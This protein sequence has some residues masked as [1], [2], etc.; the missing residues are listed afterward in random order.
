M[1]A[2]NEVIV[3]LGAIVLLAAA[4]FVWAYWPTEKRVERAAQAVQ[5]HRRGETVVRVDPVEPVVVAGGDEERTE[6]EEPVAA[7]EPVDEPAFPNDPMWWD[8]PAATGKRWTASP[9]EPTPL[10]SAPGKHRYPEDLVQESFTDSWN[11]ADLIAE[12]RRQEA[13]QAGVEAA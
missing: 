5:R 4:V 2:L 9:D 11:R 1:S 10:F 13:Q 12:I 6:D 8:R 3:C 7:P